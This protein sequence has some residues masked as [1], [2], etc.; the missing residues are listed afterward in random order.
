MCC[1]GKP[2]INGEPSA[3]SWDGKSFCTYPIAPP[4]IP[5][6]A[7]V[8]HDEPG[9]CGKLDCHCHHFCV[10]RDGCRVVLL[11]RNGTGDHRIELCGEPIVMALDA[12]DSSTR[13][14]TLHAIYGC[15]K[16]AARDATDEEAARWQK[17]AV[18]KRIRTRK[19]PRRGVVKVWI[20]NAA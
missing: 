7:T 4:K 8:L 15:S 19:Y 20:E 17:A 3:Y 6:G 13:F 12:M 1:C 5:E 16:S 10:V 11:T 9:R 14:W 2:T 18:D